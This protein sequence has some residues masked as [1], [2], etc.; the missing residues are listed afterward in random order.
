M[1]ESTPTDLTAEQQAL[2][3]RVDELWRLSML[4]DEH[5]IRGALH[6]EYVGWDT[7]A[8]LPHDRESAVRSV[9]GSAARLLRYRLAPLSVRIYGDAVGVV[10]YRYEATVQ[11]E[12]GPPAEVSGRWTEAYLRL[13]QQWLMVS[14]SGRPDPAEPPAP[15]PV[16]ARRNR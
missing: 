4:K 1:D 11:T 6:P 14:V 16:S 5:R 10:H 3:Q 15:G 13:G 2:W 8:P 12:G 7:S 9:A